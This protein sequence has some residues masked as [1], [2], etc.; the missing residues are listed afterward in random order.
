M[1]VTTIIDILKI[2]GVAIIPLL[3]LGIIMTVILLDKAILHRRYGA[4]P[5]SLG[6]LVEKFGFDWGQFHGEV[7][8][9]HPR[10]FYRR[11]FS[12]IYNNHTRP[13]WWVESRAGD[14]ALVI[15][16]EMNEG[17]WALETIVTAAPLIGL[18][19]TIIGMMN[20]FKVIGANGLTRPEQVTGGVAQALVATAFGLLIALIALF[21]YNY[22]SRR[23]AQLMDEMERLGTRAIDHIR[24]DQESALERSKAA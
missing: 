6:N 21:G 19:G 1:N 5:E 11:F 18:L 4:L 7:D 2:G 8:R 3:V 10:N 20:A 16:K 23:N 17:L 13:A 15:E 24:L 9:L 12:A 22:F 14:E